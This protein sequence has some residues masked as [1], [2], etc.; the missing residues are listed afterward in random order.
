VYLHNAYESIVSTQTSIPQGWLRKP[1]YLVN[2]R[3]DTSSRNRLKRDTANMR[4]GDQ[5]RTKMHVVAIEEPTMQCRRQKTSI[6]MG[7]AGKLPLTCIEGE[8]L[9]GI[10]LRFLIR[11][12][13]IYRVCI[14]FSLSNSP[15]SST[16]QAH[17]A[18]SRPIPTLR[19]NFSALHLCS[20]NNSKAP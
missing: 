2:S 1:R 19:L 7:Y 13:S 5:P 18:F 11:T 17:R 12:S 9:H 16:A 8:R 4:M 10:Q 20:S 3:A 14:S 6:T 15:T